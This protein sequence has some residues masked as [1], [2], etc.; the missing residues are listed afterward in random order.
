[1]RYLLSGLLLGIL[2]LFGD[3]LGS[4]KG[5]ML[6]VPIKEMKIEDFL[7]HSIGHIPKALM[8]DGLPH[9]GA[10]R[11]DWKAKPRVHAGYDIYANHVDIVASAAGVVKTVAH[12]KLSGTY[13]KLRHQ[14]GVETLYIHVTKVYVKEGER[15]KRDQVIARIDGAAGNAVAPQLHYEIKLEKKRHFD[16]LEVIK[17][18]YHNDRNLMDLISAYE[19]QIRSSILTRD[20]LVKQ[21]LQKRSAQ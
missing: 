21:Y 11:D 17:S 7:K 9:F 19:T 6:E 3:T 18:H 5:L 13:I 8:K 20:Q 14:K 16:P 1:M 15:V 12:G 2:P 10:K 4:V